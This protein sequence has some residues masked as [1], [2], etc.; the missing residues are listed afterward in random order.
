MEWIASR[1]ETAV[2]DIRKT[3]LEGCASWFYD[4]EE[5]CIRNEK[6]S[7]FTITGY[8]LEGEDGSSRRQP[9]IIQPEIGYLGILCR[10]FDGVMH[11]LM[12]AKIEPGNIK[13]ISLRSTAG[14]SRPIWIIS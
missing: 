6:R 5:G 3:T 4:R 7:F 12:Q 14:K 8:E 2:V 1:N 9:I 13:A 11:F 10:E